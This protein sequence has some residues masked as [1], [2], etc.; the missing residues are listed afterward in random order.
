MIFEKIGTQISENTILQKH[1]TFL[2]KRIFFLIRN[3]HVSAGLCSQKLEF[4]ALQRSD[5]F[6]NTLHLT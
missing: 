6:P 2:F 5:F 3:F 4:Q 1:K